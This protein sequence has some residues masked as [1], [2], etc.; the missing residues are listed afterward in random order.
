MED[1]S[2]RWTFATNFGDHPDGLD[3]D[4][5]LSDENVKTTAWRLG[6]SALTSCHDLTLTHHLDL[7]GEEIRTRTEGLGVTIAKPG[8]QYTPQATEFQQ[9]FVNVLRGDEELREFRTARSSTISRSTAP[10]GQD[11]V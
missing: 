4:L 11:T 1:P 2:L 10:D 3:V 5:S 6:I 7:N 9:A 8:Q